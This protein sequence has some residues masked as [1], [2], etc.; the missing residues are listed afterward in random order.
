MEQSPAPLIV[1]IDH[2][3]LDQAAHN[4][5]EA[6]RREQ[7]FFGPA[8]ESKPFPRLINRVVSTG[9]RR[10]GAVVDDEV[11]GMCRVQADGHT[12]IV[13]ERSWRRQGIGRSLLS[14]A[15]DRAGG[16]GLE[17]LVLQTSRRGLGVA[18]LGRSVGAAVIDQGCGR[19]DLV[20]PTG[21]L[22]RTA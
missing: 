10:L 16:E 13:V 6:L 20:I 15:I 14:A 3:S 22:T 2:P 4:F 8:S 5:A 11:V 12:T 17:A 19:I 1:A 9:A 21:A 7:R 18:A